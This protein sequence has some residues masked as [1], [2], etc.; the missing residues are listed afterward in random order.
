MHAPRLWSERAICPQRHCVSRLTHRYR[1]PLYL[2]ASGLR[3][4][5]GCLS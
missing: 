2:Y 5:L 4:P 3:K 1:L